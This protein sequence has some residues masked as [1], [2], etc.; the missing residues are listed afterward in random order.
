MVH[1]DDYASTGMMKDLTWMK[2]CLENKYQ[3]KTQMLGPNEGHTKQIKVLNRVI[4]WDNAK[5]LIYE[6]DPRHVEIINLTPV[7]GD[8]GRAR[9][10]VVAW[11]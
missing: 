10:A 2:Q 4:T 9:C 8:A 1:G 5:G 7:N 6:A 3:V 11:R